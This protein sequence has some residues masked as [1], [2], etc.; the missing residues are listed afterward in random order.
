MAWASSRAP[1]TAYPEAMPGSLDPPLHALIR[2]APDV[3]VPL[4]ARQGDER[5]LLVFGDEAAAQAHLA[6]LPA[7]EA[8]AWTTVRLEADDWRGKEELF[9]A[10]ATVGATRLDLDP[11]LT[12][13][14]R[15]ILPLAQAVA[16][17]TSYKRARACL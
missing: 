15:R 2:H 9:R 11:D 5:S 6:S 4:V 1:R 14:P 12:L 8:G 13:R 10:A 17:A 3:L 7:G 16:Y